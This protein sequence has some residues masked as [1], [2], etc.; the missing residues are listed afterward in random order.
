[1]ED[2]ESLSWVSQVSTVSFRGAYN[3]RYGSQPIT[4]SHSEPCSRPPRQLSAIPRPDHS[5]G[6]V[7]GGLERV[8]P[9]GGS[10][11]LGPKRPEPTLKR[12]GRQGSAGSRRACIGE[13]ARETAATC[14][15]REPSESLPS[16]CKGPC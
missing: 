12:L 6:Q 9:C 10:D 15:P 3:R 1:M 8:P 5:R 2:K 7:W 14:R 11:R 4:G 16:A 13:G